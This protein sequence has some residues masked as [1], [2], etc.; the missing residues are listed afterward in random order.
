[1]KE[2]NNKIDRKEEIKEN[3][4]AIVVVT[5]IAVFFG[6]WIYTHLYAPAE[7]QT[8]GTRFQVPL[9][10]SPVLGDENASITVVEFSDFECPFCG[11]YSREE[12]PQIKKLYIDTRKVRYVFKQFPL[13]QIHPKA[14]RAAQASLCAQEQG[15]FWQYHDELYAHQ[16]ELELGQLEA[17]AKT[18]GLDTAVFHN[19]LVTEKTLPEL[20]IDKKLGLEIGVS[21]TPTFFFNGRKVAGAITVEEFGKEVEEEMKIASTTA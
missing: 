5:F 6:W 21:G 13:T 3:I 8:D 4:I 1:M 12:F 16:N 20:F 9:A 18:L 10:S 14:Q 7:P 19:C 2:T 11:R 17:Y 15:A